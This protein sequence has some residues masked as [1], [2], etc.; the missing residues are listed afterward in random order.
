M[1][2]LATAITLPNEIVKAS[3]FQF[4]HDQQFKNTALVLS[5]LF[6]EGSTSFI[7]GGTVS[8]YE[9]GG[10]AIQVSPLLVFDSNTKNTGIET[11]VTAPISVE[12][13]D[14][15]DRI[16]T[17]QVNIQEEAYDNESRAFM[18]DAT[19]KIPV[20]ENI[21]TKK[22]IVLTISV[23]KG[24]V[25]AAIAPAVDS[26][27]VKLAEISVPA[28]TVNITSSL[29]NNI[30][31]RVKN[32]ENTTWTADKKACFS[33]LYITQFLQSFLAE[34]AEDGS[35][36]N[37][38]IGNAALKYGVGS[39]EINASMLPIGESVSVENTHFESVAS[40]KEIIKTIAD[41]LSGVKA[42]ANTVLSRYEYLSDSPIVASTENIDVAL[43]GELE[44][45]GV[46]LSAGQMVLL[47]DQTDK[48]ENG[49]WI[50]QT[51][52]WNR[53]DGYKDG[54]ATLDHKLI[55]IMSG[56]SNAKKSFFLPSENNTI[57]E[58]E[59]NFKEA[60]FTAEAMAR[61]FVIR[62]ENARAKVET[63]AEAKDIANKGYVDTLVQES[64]YTG[65]TA[66]EDESMARNLLD[67]LGIR[68][69]HSDEPATVE[70]VKA[71]IAILQERFATKRFQGLRYCDYLDLS[72]LTVDG[73]TYQWNAQHK[74]LRFM[75]MGFDPFLHS[76]DAGANGLETH[77]ILFQ[78]RNC[79]LEKKMNETD[80]NAG[81]YPAS[82][83]YTWLND[84]FKAGLED[85][86]GDNLLTI[87]RLYSKNDSWS[88]YNDT[89]FLPHEMEVWGFPNWAKA[90]WDGGIQTIWKPYRDSTIYKIK[91][92]NGNRKGWWLCTPSKYNGGTLCFCYSGS[93]AGAWRSMRTEFEA[94]RK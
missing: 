84:K 65:V 69:V 19:T 91:Y 31:A 68:A 53:A 29:I 57:G 63:P 89:V 14:V 64:T 71:A 22:K 39:D 94:V 67:V 46:E 62:D 23:K 6:E 59:L 93:I 49:L 54:A 82:V 56:T 58:S 85:I 50:V 66:F 11:E 34:H 74:N 81:G 17:V 35:H 37:A 77:H 88:W 87:R 3:D 12:A 55:T 20:Y 36:K 33:P 75:I 79:I 47:K 28:G 90:S 15:L 13:A 30:T 38:V 41:V 8:P 76:G 10:M 45:D 83:M 92:L 73:V 27:C 43:G 5:A 86:F 2:N 40:T 26:G 16:D 25:G 21:N 1:A 7:L 51:G 44:I 72:E 60:N 80:T 32:A 70:E 4:S 52:S 42:Y 78:A 18:Y 61:N 24:A 9:H 48:K